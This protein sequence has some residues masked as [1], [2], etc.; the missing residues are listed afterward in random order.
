VSRALPG[1]RDAAA[2]PQR[3]DRWA[4]G[5]ARGRTLAASHE[6]RVGDRLPWGERRDEP[7]EPATD[8]EKLWPNAPSAPDVPEPPSAE[9]PPAM[10][11]APAAEDQVAASLVDEVQRL[12]GE[13]EQRLT[14]T[15]QGLLADLLDEREQR[16]TAMEVVLASLRQSV[17]GLDDALDQGLGS[18]ATWRDELPATTRR[19]GAELGRDVHGPECD[20]DEVLEAIPG[21]G[22]ARRRL[23]ADTFGD[24]AS[25]RGASV[26]QLED[27]PGITG[28]LA[29]RIHDHLRA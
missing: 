6:P 8:H 22:P 19:V 1:V 24:L 29:Q 23:L 2:A 18:L 21:V 27:L 11:V 15:L 26:E 12:L 7:A 17:T 13:Q 3:A 16:L 9:P 25:L 20:L 4:R 14:V 28:A 5:W 10:E